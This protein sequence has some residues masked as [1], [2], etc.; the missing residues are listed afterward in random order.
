MQSQYTP[1]QDSE[2]KSAETCTTEGVDMQEGGIS[3]ML[4]VDVTTTARDITVPIR[5][6]KWT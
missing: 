4:I 6:R 2:N 5:N 1:S 3:A